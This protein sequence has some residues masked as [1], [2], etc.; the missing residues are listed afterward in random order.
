MGKITKVESKKHDEAMA[1]LS[2]TR[3]L[4]PFEVDFVYENFNPMANNDVGKN[5]VFFTPYDIAIDLAQSCNPSGDIVDF[6]AGIGMCSWAM[7]IQLHSEPS[8]RHVAIE[9]N[10]EFVEIGKKLQ[11]NLEWYCASI[12]DLNFLKSLGFFDCA[13]GNPPYGNISAKTGTEWMLTKGPAEILTIEVAA[14]ISYN[15]GTF[16][17]PS[18]LADY[19]IDPERQKMLRQSGKSFVKDP[20]TFSTSKKSLLKAFPG[21]FFSAWDSGICLDNAMNWKGAK[22]K[23]DIVDVDPSDVTWERPYGFAD[24]EPKPVKPRV[25]IKTLKQMPNKHQ[26][27]LTLF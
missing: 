9:I 6:G 25:E 24:T 13:F 21:L 19:E 18:E 16:V 7:S 17:I 12:F 23:V 15:V 2:L 5:G 8:H 22:P 10:P 26:D 4:L 1:L 14:R 3:P 11:P 20:E 27:Q